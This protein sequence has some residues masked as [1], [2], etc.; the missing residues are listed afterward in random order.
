[1]KRIHSIGDEWGGTLLAFAVCW[2]SK[3]ANGR[4]QCDA[5][6]PILIALRNSKKKKEQMCCSW[7]TLA[8]NTPASPSSHW[9]KLKAEQ[10]IAE[11]CIYIYIYM[12]QARFCKEARK[13][14]RK[15]A[16]TIDHLQS[17]WAFPSVAAAA[18]APILVSSRLV[19]SRVSTLLLGL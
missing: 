1:M 6:G 14:G 8:V 7:G 9:G 15:E 5:Q 13:Q 4:E 10:T 2:G 18:P 16:L 19:S 3:V 11:I 12:R 17:W